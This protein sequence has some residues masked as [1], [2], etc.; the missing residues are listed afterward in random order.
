MSNGLYS[1]PAKDPVGLF[2]WW[3]GEK[4]DIENLGVYFHPNKYYSSSHASIKIF[5]FLR[6]HK[7]STPTNNAIMHRIGIENL[8]IKRFCCLVVWLG[9]VCVGFVFVWWVR[10]AVIFF[11]HK[12]KYSLFGTP[13]YVP[14]HLS[15]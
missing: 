7:K 2:L 6:H 11:C 1:G 14:Q 12:H 9:F 4:W 5:F 15:I 3:D 8:I 10:L 13:N